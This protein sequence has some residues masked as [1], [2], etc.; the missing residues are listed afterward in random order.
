[1]AGGR[2]LD[3]NYFSRACLLPNPANP[4]VHRGSQ[5][6]ART[7][8]SMRK[9]AVWSGQ[10][11]CQGVLQFVEGFP[12]ESM[13]M[14]IKL[15]GNKISFVIP[16]SRSDTGQLDATIANGVLK[17]N[18]DSRRGKAIGTGTIHTAWIDA[19]RS[20]RGTSG[21]PRHTRLTRYRCSLPGLA[22]FA[23]PRCTKPEV[24]RFDT[25][26]ARMHF[27]LSTHFP[28][29]RFAPCLS[30][31]TRRPIS[32]VF[33]CTPRGACSTLLRGWSASPTALLSPAAAARS[34]RQRTAASRAAPH[35]TGNTQLPSRAAG[36]SS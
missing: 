31:L 22:G 21:S 5:Q 20:N 13:I 28:L 19:L 1:M 23:G 32:P 36:G 12:G 18:L 3:C 15:A 16:D 26:L 6:P 2:A 35:V 24:P 27:Q 30:L 9:L 14:T 17:E 8:T 10:E 34:A 29:F 25:H 11:G 33:C 4:R 7:R